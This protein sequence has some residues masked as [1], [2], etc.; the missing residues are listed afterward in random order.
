M[1]KKNDHVYQ[2]NEMIKY[3]LTRGYDEKRLCNLMKDTLSTEREEYLTEKFT[4]S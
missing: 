1:L 4:A 2:S 3:F